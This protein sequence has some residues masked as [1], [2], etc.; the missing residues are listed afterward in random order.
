MS[1]TPAYMKRWREKHP[2]Y[3]RH[4]MRE[5]RAKAKFPRERDG[6]ILGVSIRKDFLKKLRK[7]TNEQQGRRCRYQD[8]LSV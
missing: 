2:G 1:G 5:S 3:H 8:S 6:R 7:I 4:W